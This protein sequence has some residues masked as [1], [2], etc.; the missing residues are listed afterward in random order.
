MVKLPKNNCKIQIPAEVVNLI[1]NGKNLDEF[2]K[3]VLDNIVAKNQMSKGKSETFKDLR[4][5]LL[6]ELEHNFPEKIESFR[7]SRTDSAAEFKRLAE[8]QS[9]LPNGD[10][11]MKI[12]TE[13]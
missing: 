11:D 13:H 6:K 7:Q 10:A 3:D 2:A 4:M 1:D 9:V 12:E 5:N 8:A